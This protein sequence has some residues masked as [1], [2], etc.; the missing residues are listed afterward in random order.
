M[1]RKQRQCEGNEQQEIPRKDQSS[2]ALKRTFGTLERW[3]EV[4]SLD[5]GM[6][7]EK[8]LKNLKKLLKNLLTN[9]EVCGIIYGLPWRRVANR[10]SWQ[11]ARAIER[12]KFEKTKK[13][14]EKPLDKIEKVWY[15]SRA[16]LKRSFPK[17]ITKKVEKLLKNLLTKSRRCDIIVGH[18]RRE[19]EGWFER[20]TKNF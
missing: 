20:A 6:R 4:T 9:Q 1:E 14:F 19:V 5:G 18:F 12:K 10:R 17:K 8:T 15:N 3:K 13:T 16:L 2:S 7:H 11:F